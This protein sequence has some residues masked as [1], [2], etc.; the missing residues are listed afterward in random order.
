LC[1]NISNVVAVL[2]TCFNSHVTTKHGLAGLVHI[3]QNKTIDIS[4]ALSW[5]FNSNE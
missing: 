3:L 2:S 4:I 1:L 5:V